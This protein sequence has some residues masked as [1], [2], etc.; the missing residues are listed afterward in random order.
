MSRVV[1][2][3]A[4]QTDVF[5]YGLTQAQLDRIVRGL[6][7]KE[8]WNELNKIYRAHIKATFPYGA[9]AAEGDPS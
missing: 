8:R 3:W 5:G 1:E 9:A 6:R 2:E 7:G 4:A